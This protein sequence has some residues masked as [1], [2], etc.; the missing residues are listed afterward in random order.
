MTETCPWSSAQVHVGMAIVAGN[1]TPRDIQAYLL[2][3]FG[4]HME[5]KE[6]IRYRD[7]IPRLE[8]PQRFQKY[9]HW[10]VQQ[11]GERARY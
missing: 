4:Q 5:K 11:R 3:K 8:N 9:C 1:W 2:E 10:L 6:I 7:G